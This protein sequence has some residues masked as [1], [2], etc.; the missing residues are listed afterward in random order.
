MSVCPRWTPCAFIARA[1]SIRSL[2]ISGMLYLSQRDLDDAAIRKNFIESSGLST[3]SLERPR[4]HVAGFN[5]FFADLDDG[6]AA[7]NSLKIV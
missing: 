4:T 6:D 3:H 7:L 5:I 1:M 2:T